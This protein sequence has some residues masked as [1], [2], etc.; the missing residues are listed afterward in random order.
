MHILLSIV[1][2][3]YLSGCATSGLLEQAENS[4]SPRL[5]CDYWKIKRVVSAVK[6]KNGDISI[7][8]ELVD[9]NIS[10]IWRICRYHPEITY[11]DKEP[12]LKTIT[13]S[14]SYLTGDIAAGVDLESSE[15]GCPSYD[16][17]YPVEKTKK[18]CDKIISESLSSMADLPIERLEVQEKDKNELYDLLNAYNENSQITEK[19]YEVSFGNYDEGTDKATDCDNRIKYVSDVLLVYWSTKISQREVEP[20][21]IAGTYEDQRHPHG[22]LLYL[23]LPL[24]VATDVLLG[25]VVVAIWLYPLYAPLL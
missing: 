5:N 13:L 12:E 15:S 24:T 21:I 4:S 16:A 8:V 17:L 20:I 14:F 6:Q 22:K 23:L 11:E 1:L 3:F 9:I 7:C 25:I 18:G 2:L 19:L 10:E